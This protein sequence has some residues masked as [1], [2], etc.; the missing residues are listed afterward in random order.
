MS[1]SYCSSYKYPFQGKVLV[2]KQHLE[3]LLPLSFSDIVIIKTANCKCQH[4]FVI[5][6]Q[7]KSCKIFPIN[8]NFHLLACHNSGSALASKHEQ[9]IWFIHGWNLAEGFSIKLWAAAPQSLPCNS[10]CRRLSSKGWWLLLGISVLHYVL[11]GLWTHSC[12]IKT[13]KICRL[14]DVQAQD[15]KSYVTI[16]SL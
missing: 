4:S 5:W 10:L 8:S 7:L 13:W 15:A 2:R 11:A 6:T 12:C 16:L 9:I 14:C 3:Y 1:Y